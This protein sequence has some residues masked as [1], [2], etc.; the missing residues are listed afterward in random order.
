MKVADVERMQEFI[1]DELGEMKIAIRPELPFLAE[2]CRVRPAQIDIHGEGRKLTLTIPEH[3]RVAMGEVE[4]ILL[5]EFS[6]EGSSPARELQLS[7]SR[8]PGS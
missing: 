6:K 5:L 2:G 1:V 3:A 4:E 7:L 8:A